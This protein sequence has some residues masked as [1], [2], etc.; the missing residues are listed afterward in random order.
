MRRGLV[1][2]MAWMLATGAAV[3]LCWWGVH[4]VM[5][6]TAYDRPLAVP[7]T[8]QPLSSSTQRAQPQGSPSP[9]P[10]ASPSPSPSQSP[11]ATASPSAGASADKPSQKPSASPDG[12][13]REGGQD[14][15]KVQAYPVSGGRVTFSLGDSSAELVSATP[16]AGWRMQVWKQD[17]WI[18]VT[19]T[20][21]GREVSVFCT[22]HDH[23]PMVEIVDP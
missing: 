17:F 18:R 20:R 19:F 21:D 7:L 6:G 8:G 10:S 23:P 1:H 5:S 3:T 11:G 2:A 13:Q 22:W 4:T 14:S 16:A 12:R 15:G 9:A